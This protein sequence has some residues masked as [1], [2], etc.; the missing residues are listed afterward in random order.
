LRVITGKFIGQ[1]V[2]D[3]FD[4]QARLCVEIFFEW[5]DHQHLVDHAGDFFHSAR[6]PGPDLGADVEDGADP[7]FLEADREPEV[8]SGIIAEQGR[9]GFFAFG[10]INHSGH[11]PAKFGQAFDHV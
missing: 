5:K 6:F 1:R 9:V 3:K 2:A 11:D 7:D 10:D 4:I 8:E